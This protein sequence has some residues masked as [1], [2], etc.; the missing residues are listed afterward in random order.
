MCSKY[1]LILLLTLLICRLQNNAQDMRSVSTDEQAV[2]KLTPE[3]RMELELV[4]TADSMLFFPMDEYRTACNDRFIP[5]LVKYLRR[6]GSFDDPMDS[7]R[8]KVNIIYPEDSSFRIFNWEIKHAENIVRYYG[9]IQFN[10]KDLHLVPLI[11]NSTEEMDSPE[12]S[13]FSIKNWYGGIIYKIKTVEFPDGHKL[14][15][16]FSTNRNGRLSNKKIMDILFLD[17]R[18]PAHWGLPIINTPEGPK[19]RYILEFNKLANVSFN[20]NEEK[21]LVIFDELRS[22]VNNKKLR[23]TYIPIGEYHGF[24]WNGKSWNYIDKLVEVVE[25]S[26]EQVPVRK[27]DSSKLFKGGNSAS[28]GKKKRKTKN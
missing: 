15:T 28:K 27:D 14:Y 7:L 1:C 21:G 23:Y 3:K 10:E 5:K 4:R 6:P 24:S 2:Y 13:S 8:R 9:A 19:N 11:D 18:K 16:T 25:Y 20:Y 26:P 22:E 12:D 17:D